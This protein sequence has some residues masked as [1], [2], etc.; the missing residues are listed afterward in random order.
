[1]AA[2]E[3]GDDVWQQDPPVEV[4]VLAVGPTVIRSVIREIPAGC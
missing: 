4:A 2:A 3:V 1:M